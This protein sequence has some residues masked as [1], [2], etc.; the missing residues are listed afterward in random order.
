MNKIIDIAAVIDS[1]SALTQE[2]GEKVYSIIADS[3]SRKEEITLDFGNVESM[4]TPFSNT[5][6]A[7]TSFPL[8]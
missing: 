6:I 4:I 2:Q 7:R 1:P 3:M 5:A 8:S